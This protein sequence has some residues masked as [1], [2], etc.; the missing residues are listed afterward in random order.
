[1]AKNYKEN[2]QIIS[3]NIDGDNII[4]KYKKCIFLLGKNDILILDLENRKYVSF[5]CDGKSEEQYK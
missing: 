3:I 2:F 1:M 5:D 4:Y